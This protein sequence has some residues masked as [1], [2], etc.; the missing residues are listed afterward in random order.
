MNGLSLRGLWR[1]KAR[2]TSSLPLPDSPLIN[3]V[4]CERLKRP[5]ALK[6]SCMAGAWPMISG[7]SSSAILSGA[8]LV[9][10]STARLITSMAWSTSNGLARYSKSAALEGGYCAFKVGIS[11][12]DDDRNIRI[13]LFDFAQ[14]IQSGPFGMR[15]SLTTTCGCSRSS[16]LSASAT[17]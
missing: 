3:T 7:V 4:A 6:T 13:F 9:L 14:K 16:A 17:D 12:H 11:G 2:A 10:S 1:C 5:M 15:M 8:C